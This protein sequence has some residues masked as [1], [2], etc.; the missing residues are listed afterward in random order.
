M[1][2]LVVVW[3]AGV[4]LCFSCVL[5][6]DGST[7]ARL[8]SVSVREAP[9]EWQR[10]LRDLSVRIHVP[11]PV[12][13]PISPRVAVPAAVG[14]LRPVVLMPIGALTGLPVEHIKALLAHELAHVR[15]A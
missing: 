10:T 12:E 1:P 11:R 8:R 6:L 9:P 2:S 15:L 7:L 3:F 14:W 5:L 4:S 13:I